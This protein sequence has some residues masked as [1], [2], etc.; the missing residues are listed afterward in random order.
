MNDTFMLVNKHII[1]KPL[2]KTNRIIHCVLIKTWRAQ[3]ATTLFMLLLSALPKLLLYFFGNIIFTFQID[4]SGSQKKKVHFGSTIREGKRECRKQ[5][6]SAGSNSHFFFVK[7]SNASLSMEGL[8]C[9]FIHYLAINLFC[10][11]LFCWHCW[12]VTGAWGLGQN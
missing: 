1:I 4:H 6:V 3:S 2:F 12:E 10:Y 11:L 8:G 5:L 9:S 7:V